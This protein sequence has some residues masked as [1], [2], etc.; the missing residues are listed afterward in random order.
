MSALVKR[1]N[2]FYQTLLIKQ[3]AW[4]RS[5]KMVNLRVYGLLLNVT[6]DGRN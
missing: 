4:L 6:P 5:R 3:T 2:H 1:S